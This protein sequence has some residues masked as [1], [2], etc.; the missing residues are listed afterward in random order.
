MYKALLAAAVMID[1]IEASGFVVQASKEV[2][3]IAQVI[4]SALTI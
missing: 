2:L 3:C 4:Q 1:K